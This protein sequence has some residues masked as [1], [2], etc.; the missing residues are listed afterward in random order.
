MIL[1]VVHPLANGLPNNG[2]ERER[3]REREKERV[4][5]NTLRTARYAVLLCT[6]TR[7]FFPVK[8]KKNEPGKNMPVSS[9]RMRVL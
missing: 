5:E 6:A 1:Y 9:L 3:E 7:A 8:K 4:R 2:S